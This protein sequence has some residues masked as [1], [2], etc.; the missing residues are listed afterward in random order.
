MV[1]SVAAPLIVSGFRRVRRSTFTGERNNGKDR[2]PPVLAAVIAGEPAENS[3]RRV[4][5]CKPGRA[6][7]H[8]PSE[9][10]H[11]MILF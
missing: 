7:V 11:R 3:E 4:D 10:L 6:G 9:A 1:S 5:T 8:L 2:I